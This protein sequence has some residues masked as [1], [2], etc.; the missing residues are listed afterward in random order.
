MATQSEGGGLSPISQISQALKHLED[1]QT[2]L[3]QAR[4]LLENYRFN[5]LL[6]SADTFPKTP[7][8]DNPYSFP[9]SPAF[10]SRSLPTQPGASINRSAPA[11]PQFGQL[12]IPPLSPRSPR[13]PFS[14]NPA[15]P[16]PRNSTFGPVRRPSTG[17]ESESSSGS[18]KSTPK[19]SGLTISSTLA[20][21]ISSHHSSQTSRRWSV[22][23]ETIAIGVTEKKESSPP[24]I[25]GL[26][27]ALGLALDSSEME[28]L[29]AKGFA[30]IELVK[31]EKGKSGGSSSPVTA[32][33]TTKRISPTLVSLKSYSQALKSVNRGKEPVSEVLEASGLKVDRSSNGK[34][35]RLIDADFPGEENLVGSESSVKTELN[36]AEGWL[37]EETDGW[38]EGESLC[39]VLFASQNLVDGILFQF[40]P[41]NSQS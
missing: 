34:P 23:R 5:E 26:S 27:S 1:A 10:N 14:Y 8:S 24:E 12:P 16:S 40:L 28:V 35:S 39:P 15:T 13:V 2:S 33:S 38:E 21:S 41:L 29:H 32:P 6:N 22:G 36:S 7:T 11:S 25:N 4:K 30:E 31:S 18:S 20:N 19:V 3:S 37:R 9:P 17:V